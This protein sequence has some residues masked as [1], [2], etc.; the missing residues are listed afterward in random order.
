[1]PDFWDYEYDFDAGLTDVEKLSA[2]QQ[3]EHIY[4]QETE[5]N[6]DVALAMIDA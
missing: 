4:A 3:A 1:M 5:G 2:M 6:Q